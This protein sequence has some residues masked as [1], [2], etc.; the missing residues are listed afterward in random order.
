MKSVH[1][2]EKHSSLRLHPALGAVLLAIGLL[3]TALPA[4]AISFDFTLDHVTGGAGTAPF[5]TVTVTQNGT[6]V[7]VTVDLATGYSFVKTGSADFQNFKFNATGVTLADITIDA[8]APSLV[9]ATGT[10]NGNGTGDFAF[11]INAPAVGNGASGAFTSDIVFHVANA[12]IADLTAPNAL[13]NIFVADILAP[14]GNTG[15]VAVT[16]TPAPDSGSTA[17]LFAL[18]LFG[19][20]FV[21]KVQCSESR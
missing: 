19:L 3:A 2:L 4:Q 10:L 11:G 9:A 1:S 7:D 5:G 6:T 20:G 15:P 13:G 16:A 17:L 21:K 18:V 14:N 12:T 8:H